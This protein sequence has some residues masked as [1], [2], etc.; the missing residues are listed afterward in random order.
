MSYKIIE[1]CCVTGNLGKNT[2]VGYPSQ[3]KDYD[4]NLVFVHGL[5]GK[6]H[7]TWRAHD[8]IKGSSHHTYCWPIEWLPRTLGTSAGL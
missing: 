4:F 2:F 5:L 6:S 8:Q 7:R 3:H 1:N